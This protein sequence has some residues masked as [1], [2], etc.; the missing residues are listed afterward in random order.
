MPTAIS[1][2]KRDDIYQRLANEVEKGGRLPSEALF[3]HGKGLSREDPRFRNFLRAQALQGG[4][5]RW[6]PVC[7]DPTNDY[8]ALA[9]VAA[10]QAGS[11]M[12]SWRTTAAIRQILGDWD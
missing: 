6:P 8:P 7:R 5:R 11:V 9:N 4:R 12:T 3:R 2:D 10:A 1:A